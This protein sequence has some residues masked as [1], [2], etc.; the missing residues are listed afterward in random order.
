LDDYDSLCDI[1][2]YEH[3]K[4]STTTMYYDFMGRVVNPGRRV[5][6]IKHFH[7]VLHEIRDAETHRQ[8]KEDLIEER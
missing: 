2:H 7:Q 8:L 4:I 6:R 5:D 3:A 1:A